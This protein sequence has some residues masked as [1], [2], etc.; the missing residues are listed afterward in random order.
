[1]ALT[2]VRCGSRWGPGQS[3]GTTAW[4]GTAGHRVWGVTWDLLEPWVVRHNVRHNDPRPVQTNDGCDDAFASH[5]A[6]SGSTRVGVRDDP[7]GDTR[8]LVI[9]APG[10]QFSDKAIARPSIDARQMDAAL[11]RLLAV[12]LTAR[13]NMREAL[14]IRPSDARRQEIAR[15]ELLASLEGYASGLTARG[16]S[17]PPALRD[18]LALQRNL[19]R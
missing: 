11:D 15:E 17:A 12:L 13:S 16:L 19:A 18:E 6:R 3:V 9:D 10:G 2:H 1:M 14:A 8:C 7:D 5:T 4:I